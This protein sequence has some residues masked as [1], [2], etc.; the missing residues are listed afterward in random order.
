MITPR[1]SRSGP[2]GTVTLAAPAPR[3]PAACTRCCGL[4]PGG[5]TRGLTAAHAARILAAI[6]PA[7]AVGQARR[8]LAAGFADDLRRLDARQRDTRRKLA[9]AVRA[10]GT[11]VTEVHGAGPV[12]AGIVTGDVRDVNRFPGRDHSAA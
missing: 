8:D 2:S 1:C 11:T 4:V 5:V 7:S 9:A 3:W 10:S 6:T 12:V